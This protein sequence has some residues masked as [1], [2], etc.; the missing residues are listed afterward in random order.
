MSGVPSAFLGAARARAHASL[1]QAVN[2]ERLPLARTGKN[3][4]NDVAHIRAVQAERDASAQAADIVLGEVR[5]GARVHDWPHSRQASIAAATSSR[6]SG[7]V[8]GEASRISLVALM[9][10]GRF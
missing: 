10:N 2:D 9:A 1:Q 4:R 3:A 7:A 6:P 5:V 8:V